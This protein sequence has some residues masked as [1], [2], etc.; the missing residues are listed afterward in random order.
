MTRVIF[1]GTPDFAVPALQALIDQSDYEMMMVVTQPDR[2]KGRGKKVT[3]PPVKRTALAH[4][5]KVMQP[6]SLQDTEVVAELRDAAPDLIVVA[7]YGQILPTE[8][9]NLSKRGCINVHASLLPRHRGADPISAAILANDAE[10]GVTVMLMAE[11]LDTGDI[12]A[13]A[14]CPIT[15]EDTKLTLTEKLAEL[16]A[17]LLLDTLPR[18]LAREIKPQSQDDSLATYAGQVQKSDGLI[19]WERSAVEI[20]RQGRAY[21]PWPGLYTYWMGKRLKIIAARALPGVRGEVGIV[22]KL[23][24]GIA[25][26]T[27]GGV[28]LLEEVQLAGKRAMR[29]TD[30]VNGQRDFIGSRLGVATDA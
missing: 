13:Q 20:A 21:T 1:M 7:A 14:R 9:L 23:S 29:A 3:A 12:L 25:V 4:D 19:D 26:G 16:G 28:L 10:T 22:Q 30:F 6:E 18:W 5:V 15:E 8:V 27:G 11:G 24:E 17:K 2:A